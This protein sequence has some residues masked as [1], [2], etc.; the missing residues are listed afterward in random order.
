MP[1]ETTGIIKTVNFLHAPGNQDYPGRVVAPLQKGDGLGALHGMDLTGAWSGDF[2]AAYD[3]YNL[4]VKDA[5]ADGPYGHSPL[6]ADPGHGAGDIG[7]AKGGITDVLG[8]PNPLSG[9]EAI[10]HFF[11]LLGQGATWVRIGEIL[12]GAILFAFAVG[13]FR[14]DVYLSVNT[15]RGLVNTVKKVAEAGAVSG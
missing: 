7:A 8:I 6:L 5:A 3:S 4:F 13:L 11:A 10:G 15:G 1:D 2:P 9:L 14:N 12:G